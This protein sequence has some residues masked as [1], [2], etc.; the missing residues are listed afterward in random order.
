MGD[1]GPTS[2]TDV[3]DPIAVVQTFSATLRANAAEQ[4]LVVVRPGSITATLTALVPAD[5]LVVGLAVGTWNGTLCR[6]V[7]ARDDATVG[8]SMTGEVTAEG[9]YCV[10][11]FDSGGRVVAPV[12]YDVTVTHY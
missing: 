7:L 8:A 5:G 2:P 3:S 4:H 6:D 12:E 1:D 9:S 11:V 10:R